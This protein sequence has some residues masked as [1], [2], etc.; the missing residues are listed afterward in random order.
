MPSALPDADFAPF[1]FLVPST[2]L[3]VAGAGLWAIGMGAQDSI[4][5]AAIVGRVPKHEHARA[6]G[7]FFERGARPDGAS[8]HAE[9]SLWSA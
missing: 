9:S 5:K 7:V 8:T 2:G 3:L 1:A 4:F 6:Y